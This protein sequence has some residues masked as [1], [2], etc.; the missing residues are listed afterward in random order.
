MSR[1]LGPEDKVFKIFHNKIGSLYLQRLGP[2]TWNLQKHLKMRNVSSLWLQLDITSREG[3]GGQNHSSCLAILDLKINLWNI[4]QQ[5]RILIPAEARS[6]TWNWISW[7]WK[8]SLLCD[9]SCSNVVRQSGILTSR[10]CDKHGESR[11]LQPFKIF[12]LLF[13]SENL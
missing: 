8:T 4:S 13:H 2:L 6:Y 7:R 3:G 12:W 11:I 1:H 5:V 10:P 9:S